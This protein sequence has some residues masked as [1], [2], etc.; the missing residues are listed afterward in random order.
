[1]NKRRNKFIIPNPIKIYG[2][3]DEGFVIDNHMQK[4]V[5]LGYD[6]YGKEIFEN[7]RT[8]IGELIYRF[9]YKKDIKCLS[10][11]INIVQFALNK[12]EL[13]DKFDLIIPVPPSNKNR[14][15]QPVFE[16]AKEV[17]KCYGKECRIDILSKESN[18]QVK[19]G[20]NVCGKIR[21]INCFEKIS[22]ILVIDDLYSTGMTLNEVCKIIKKDRKVR[23]IYCL[24][25]TKTKG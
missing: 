14:K 2:V 17:A 4:S 11:I 24:V 15:F 7:T 16:I 22:N 6:K 18:L 21:Q 10:K 20:Y 5:F 12:S 1:M 8:E 3:W 19:D 23:K 13:K 9:K 25:M